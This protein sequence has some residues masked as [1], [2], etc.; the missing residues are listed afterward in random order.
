MAT[1]RK[2]LPEDTQ[3]I[4]A[5]Y[6]ANRYEAPDI[7]GQQVWLAEDGDR[8]V[9][10][11]RLVP[12]DDYLVLRGMLIHPD[13]RRQ[14]IGGQLLAHLVPHM[15]GHIC[16][17]LPW[18]HLEAFYN[19]AGFRI[20]QPQDLPAVLA[21]RLAGHTQHLTDESIQ[22]AMQKGLDAYPPGGLRFIAMKRDRTD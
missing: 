22:R 6:Q 21:E 7:S 9:G 15:D 18:S 5:L 16:Y 11:V 3:R 19:G 12:T 17:C 8:L 2:S 10:V 4:G 20:I 14:G 1:I 13:Y